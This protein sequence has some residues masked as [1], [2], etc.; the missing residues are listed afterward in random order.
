MSVSSLFGRRFLF[1]T[2]VSF[3]SKDTE[4]LRTKAL[5]MVACPSVP[6]AE[7]SEQSVGEWPS[8]TGKSLD[9]GLVVFEQP[10]L[11]HRRM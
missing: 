9:C 8:A 11:G 5:I 3:A 4:N 7:Q 1:E 6:A 2:Q 10:T